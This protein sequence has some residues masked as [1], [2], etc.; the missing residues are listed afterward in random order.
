MW[1]GFHELPQAKKL[2]KRPATE[3][4]LR[5]R[6]TSDPT[7]A[8]IDTI[9]TTLKPS[10]TTPSSSPNTATAKTIFATPTSKGSAPAI[11]STWSVDSLSKVANVNINTTTTPAAM[12]ISTPSTFKGKDQEEEEKKAK[13][14][15]DHEDEEDK[16]GLLDNFMAELGE[17][18][19]D[20]DNDDGKTEG[21]EKTEKGETIEQ[22]VTNETKADSKASQDDK[23][24]KE[25]TK[26]VELPGAYV[27]ELGFDLLRRML[28]YDPQKRISAAEAL[29]HPYFAEEPAALPRS[30]MPKLPQ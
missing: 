11:S 7:A 3:G 2:T 12:E 21:A 20:D 23:S 13:E 9:R 28:T 24:N 10:V 16:G 22:T 17:L 4:K 5:S 30:Q 15:G 27:S 8:T 25:P 6:F 19:G 1:P 14:E 29:K 26:S 18:N